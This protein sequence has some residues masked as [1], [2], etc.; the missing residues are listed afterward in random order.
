MGTLP[1]VHESADLWLPFNRL[2][3][4]MEVEQAFAS[5]ICLVIGLT[6][7]VDEALA[8]YYNDKQAWYESAQRAKLWRVTP[9][10]RYG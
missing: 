3:L 6:G 5:I 7:R 2:M 9:H 8:V 4:L 10:G 1:L